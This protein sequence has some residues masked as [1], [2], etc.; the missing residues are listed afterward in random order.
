MNRNKYHKIDNKIK[1][2]ERVG[3]YLSSPRRNGRETGSMVYEFPRSFLD[4]LLVITWQWK[5]R[6][7][8]FLSFFMV[9]SFFFLFL[10]LFLFSFVFFVF[11][12][13]FLWAE[14]HH[15]P[16]LFSFW[17]SFFRNSLFSLYF[18]SEGSFTS[19]RCYER[20]TSAARRCC[21]GSTGAGARR[22]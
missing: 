15:A 8:N 9:L 12:F 7:T 4:F 20:G 22:G 21:V 1:L 3:I 18:Y 16:P 19:G 10:L 6:K 11:F 13:F 14:S 5:D 17:S 2:H